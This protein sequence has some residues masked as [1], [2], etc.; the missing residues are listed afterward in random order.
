MFNKNKEKSEKITIKDILG[1]VIVSVIVSFLFLTFFR[2]STVEGSSMSNTLADKDKLILST[3]TYKHSTP[4]HDDIIVIEKEHLSVKYLIKRIIGLPGDKI[5]IKDNQLFINDKQIIENYIKETMVTP[6]MEFI[7]P[8]G[9]L[10]VMGDN[11][12]NSLDGRTNTIGMIDI[13]N[14]V[15]GRA[16]FDITKFKSLF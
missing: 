13:Q 8:E 16:V 6:D 1:T 15:F 5:V 12:N 7:V 3:F 9:K 11:R 10:F 2:F 4:K 14:E